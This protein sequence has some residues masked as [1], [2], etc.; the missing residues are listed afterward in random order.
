M[1]I[2]PIAS[3]KGGVGKSLIAT[4]L[5]IALAEAEKK[6]VLA[7]LDLGGSNIHMFLGLR[8]VKSGI[9]TFLSGS[10][11]FEK[12][13]TN[14]DFNGL[15]FIPGDAEIPGIA[16]L[17][18]IQKRKLIKNL[19]ALD[20]DY[21]IIDLG[22]GTSYN[23]MDYF[24][25]ASSGIIVTTPTLVAIL[26][27]YLFLKNAIFRIM[28]AAFP[29]NS[30]AYKYLG[31]VRDK[32]SEIQ[33]IYIPKFLQKIKQ[34]DKE[35]YQKYTRQISNFSPFLILNM[36]DDPKNTD[37]AGQLRRSVREYLDIDLEHLGVIYKD[38]LHDVALNSRI[39]IIKY[40]PN[41]IISQGIYRIADK[42]LQLESEEK[43]GPIDLKTLDESYKIAEMEAEI[44][45]QSK[46]NYIEEL[47][48]CGELSKG[49]LIET[50]K[51]QQFEIEKLKNEN[52]LLKKKL[53]RAIQEGFSA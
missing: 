36:L 8:S 14:T 47:L 32:T 18:H 4:N 7:D 19:L 21:L 41:S 35:S 38:A 42:I 16:D 9:G 51:T 46:L 24:L 3:G 20:A 31:K 48:H 37:K 26:N 53:V 15:R 1:K 33:K 5:A 25:I 12:I 40:K 29:K 30:Q 13:I 44:D 22:A 17:T 49:D 27:A 10:Q 50:I 45:F 52:N 23:I 28:Y 2:L 11:K 6:V 34:I 39:P 43:E